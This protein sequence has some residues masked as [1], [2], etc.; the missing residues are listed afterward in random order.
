M[1]LHHTHCRHTV[2]NPSHATPRHATLGHA[3]RACDEFA[4]AYVN[5][6]HHRRENEDQ[7]SVISIPPPRTKRTANS[8][9]H[10]TTATSTSTH[11]HQAR[12]S[13]RSEADKGTEGTA[14]ENP[15]PLKFDCD[16]AKWRSQV[17]LCYL[18]HA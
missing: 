3:T 8:H 9:A 16:P 6:G 11:C 2:A 7:C 18:S 15:D 12:E 5:P 4:T 13:S 14:M 17:R 10:H 1:S